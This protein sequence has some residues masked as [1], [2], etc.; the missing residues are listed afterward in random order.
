MTLS[1]R[2][3]SIRATPEGRRSIDRERLCFEATEVLCRLME[4]RRVS[5]AELARRLG[6]TPARVSQLLS[7]SRNL[8]L[9]SLAEAFHVLGRSVHIVH[10]PPT[11]RAIVNAKLVERARSKARTGGSARRKPGTTRARG[12]GG[13]KRGG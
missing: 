4:D 6:V 3:D 8:T 1:R 2:M 12:G 10:G 7:G 11:E 5:S 13:R 9:A